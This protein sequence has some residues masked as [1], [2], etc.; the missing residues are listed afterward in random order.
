MNVDPSGEDKPALRP[1]PSVGMALLPNELRAKRARRLVVGAAFALVL[2]GFVALWLVRNVWPQWVAREAEPETQTETSVIAVNAIATPEGDAAVTD[3]LSPEEE[4]ALQRS[5][6]N[7]RYETPFGGVPSFRGALLNAGLDPAECDQIERALQH[8]VD[9]RRCRPEHKL[10]VERD[11]R[12]ALKQFEYHPSATEFVEVSRGEDG[13]F[14]AEQIRIKVERDPIARATAVKTSIGDGLSEIG[15]PPGFAA[16]F[17]EAFEGRIDFPLQAREGDVFRILVDEER[18]EGEF[19]RYGRVHAVEYDGQKTG[20][21][22]AFY[23]E[24]P[25]VVGQFYDESGRAMQGGWLRTPLRYDRLSSGFNPKRFHPILKRTMPHLGIDYAASTGT[26]VWAAADGRV[27]FAG[28]KGANGNLVVIRHSSGFETSYA[29]LH[30][31]KGGIRPGVQ[32]KQRELIGFV[33]STG[34]STG[35]HLHFGL[36]KHARALDPA[37]ELN[38][39]GRRLGPRELPAFKEAV[40][41]QRSALEGI[42]NAPAV[43]VGEDEPLVEPVDEIMD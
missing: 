11:D 29:H 3:L 28:R 5:S 20:K 30:R 17:T 12:G 40:V 38:G 22:A 21:Q 18:V 14:R 33:G 42:E 27:T 34:R 15:L 6:P 9:F 2:V 23:Y 35:P 37:S 41:A 32:V 16:F 7:A 8:I 43:V 24:A 39:P 31:I 26:P 36:K 19:L 25:N 13:L 4:L 1:L 10:V